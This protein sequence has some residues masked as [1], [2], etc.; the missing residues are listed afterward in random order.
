MHTAT[1]PDFF[2]N[3]VA[4]KNEVSSIS[5]QNL[6]HLLLNSLTVYKLSNDK[7]LLLAE[8]LLRLGPPNGFAFDFFPWDP[9]TVFYKLVVIH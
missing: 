7:L 8:R 1:W 4:T 9:Y 5:R 6:V 3:I 2:V